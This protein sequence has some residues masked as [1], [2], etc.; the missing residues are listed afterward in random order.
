MLGFE[1]LTLAPIDRN[2]IAR[3]LLT[4]E[5]TDQLNAYHARVMA[6]IGPLV[7]ADVRAWLEQAC[8]PL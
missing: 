2:A 6:T 4:D 3:E 8:A 7:P 5:E 1:A